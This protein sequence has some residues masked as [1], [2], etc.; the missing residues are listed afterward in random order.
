MRKLN[1]EYIS[2]REEYEKMQNDLSKDIIA[3]TAK[4]SDAIKDLDILLTYLDVM[5]GLASASLAPSIAYVRPKLLP[6][7][8]S[9]KIDVKQ[10]RHPCLELQDNFSYIANDVSFD[11]ETGKFYFITG[12]NMGGKST[13]IRSVALC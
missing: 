2:V 1:D 6:K 4:Y 5:V 13:Y 11:S 8:S 7:G 12:P 10:V 9:G 3:D